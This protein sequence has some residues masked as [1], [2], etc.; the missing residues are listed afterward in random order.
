MAGLATP[1]CLKSSQVWSTW[2]ACLPGTLPCPLAG[3]L[4]QLHRPVRG[5]WGVDLHRE[6]PG[7]LLIWAGR[8]SIVVMAKVIGLVTMLIVL[9]EIQGPG[10]E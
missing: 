6:E 4:A 9:M 1:R 7:Q 5:E 8:C 2:L 3:R 10:L